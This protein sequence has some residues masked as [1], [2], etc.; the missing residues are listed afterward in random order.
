MFKSGKE[1]KALLLLGCYKI[2]FALLCVGLLFASADQ[3]WFNESQFERVFQKWP[4]EGEANLASYLTA[5][6]GAHYLDLAKLGYRPG[7]SSCA[8]YPLWPHLVRW[9]APL[10]GGNLV[11]AGLLLANLFSFVG[12]LLFYR[13]AKLK[14]G[15]CNARWAL[16]F[17]L[18]F[19][20][21]LFFQF[22]YSEAL[23]FMILMA[24]FLLGDKTLQ[25]GGGRGV[26]AS[27]GAPGGH[28]CS[29]A[30]G[31][32]ALSAARTVP[33]VALPAGAGFGVRPLLCLDG[34]DD[35]QRD[36]G[37]RCPETLVGQFRVECLQAAEVYRGVSES[38]LVAWLPRL[39]AGS[40]PVHG[41]RIQFNC[42]VAVG[43]GV[44]CGGARVWV[45]AG[46]AFLV[47]L[48]HPLYDDGLPD[49][50]G[51][52]LAD[53]GNTKSALG[54]VGS[55]GGVAG[56]FVGS[57]FELVLGGVIERS[58]KFQVFSFKF[59]NR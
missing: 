42:C 8:F 18:A 14:V 37:V 33:K 6:D 48:L 2:G 50:R 22:I 39:D 41:I 10:T 7:D 27:A 49:V 26:A 32:G 3:G 43:R 17:L 58:F 23:F 56:G 54:G 40:V 15:E 35:R 9:V 31:L 21:A 16:A 29:C 25:G 19:P 12:A 30:H 38:Y 46:G 47:H 4:L 24:F 20:G 28:L 57:I 36:G 34:S 5:W 59:L 45:V 51:D 13:L 1:T 53:F 11:V 44:V 55:V 52:G